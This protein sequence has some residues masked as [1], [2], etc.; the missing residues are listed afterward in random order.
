MSGAWTYVMPARCL[1][2]FLGSKNCPGQIYLLTLIFQVNFVGPWEG[3]TPADEASPPVPPPLRNAPP[4]SGPDQ[5]TT[6]GYAVGVGT[7]LCN[8]SSVCKPPS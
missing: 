8:Y 1:F 4:H 7:T 3:T 6:G 5:K 2:E